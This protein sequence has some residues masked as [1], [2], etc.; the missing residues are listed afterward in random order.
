MH[1][2]VSG[3][4]RALEPE[5]AL[6]SGGDV[7]VSEPPGYRLRLP[8]H[9]IDLFGFHRLQD[10]AGE[11]RAAGDLAGAVRCLD[12]ALALWRGEALGG[13]PGPFAERHRVELSEKRLVLVEQRY[14]TLLALGEHSELVPEIEAL[15]HE[16]P[17]RESLWES[18]ITALKRSGR[19]MEALNHIAH[20]RGVLREELGVQP[21]T[22]IRLLHEELLMGDLTLP[23]SEPIVGR[24]KPELLSVVPNDIVRSQL[25]GR[26]LPIAKLRSYIGEIEVRRGHVVLVEGEAGVGKSAL[27]SAALASVDPLR[28]HLAWARAD[29]HRAVPLGVLRWALGLDRHGSISTNDV[30]KRVEHLCATAPLVL[31]VDDLHEADE[32]SSLVWDQLS[33]ATRSLPLLMIATSRNDVV[34]EAFAPLRR[35]MVARDDVIVQLGSLTR[36]SSSQFIRQAVGAIPGPRLQALATTALGNPLALRQMI[37]SLL[38]ENAVRT[39]SGIV[40]LRAGD[41]VSVERALVAWMAAGLDRLSATTS[42]TL[43]A[44]AVLGMRFTPAEVAA[45]VGSRPSQLVEALNE[46]IRAKVVTNVGENLVFTH[47]AQRRALYESIPRNL[48]PTLHRKAAQSLMDAG[49]QVERVCEQLAAIDDGRLPHWVMTWLVEHD[50]EVAACE[51]PSMVWLLTQALETC[52]VDDPRRSALLAMRARVLEQIGAR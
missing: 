43:R 32:A 12:S 45:L 33:L 24:S 14:Q 13:V 10:Q 22:A 7:L 5:R 3:L 6:W 38:R 41:A 25:V 52:A 18:L 27:L 50:V 11:L 2:Y 15:A 36:A 44:A 30:L 48:L 26:D 28:C 39:A 35:G 49:S 34:V 42:E 4:R 37:T 8:S 40:D 19:R 20:L 1:T 29:E 21:G 46:A 47:P 16:H 23:A 9:N 31:V 17:L 51:P